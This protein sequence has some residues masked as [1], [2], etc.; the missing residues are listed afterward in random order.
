[1]KPLCAVIFLVCLLISLP[2]DAFG[3]KK[4]P[5]V[6]KERMVQTKQE[7]LEKAKSVP[8]SDR[9]LPQFQPLKSDK[10]HFYPEPH[11]VFEKFNTPIASREVNIED[12]KS[13]LAV[14]PYL[15]SDSKFNYVAYPRFYF[16]SE[17]NQIS[18][19]FFVEKLDT[20]LNRK[21]RLLNYIHNQKTRVPVAQSGNDVLYK[22][23]YSGLSL[24]DWSKDSKKVL[25]KEK[26]G[27]LL[28]GI[29]KTYMYV[30]FVDDDNPYT[31]KL[32]NFDNAIKKY[33][34]EWQNIQIVKYRY[35]I[36]PLGFSADNDDL[37]LAYC[38]ALGENNEKV[39]LGLWGYNLTTCESILISKIP[40]KVN[41]SSNGIFL[42]RVID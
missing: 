2:C 27:S 37:I 41:V 35:D 13:K 30:Y 12:I 34:L 16:Q 42:K 4:K 14:I 7:W 8:L 20:A 17:Y 36:T 39:F 11:Y 25:F 28:N 15:I 32:D 24:V 19:A 23:L 40:I 21:D 33:F 38:Y 3:F 1:M 6:Q 26:I 9:E 10:K 29:Y 5:Q 18:S 22:N 31:I